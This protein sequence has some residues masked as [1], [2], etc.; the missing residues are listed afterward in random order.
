MI[1][2]LMKARKGKLRYEE[3]MKTYDDAGIATVEE[4]H[5]GTDFK[6]ALIGP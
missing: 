5:I 1:H 6:Q 4:S 2:L 3:T